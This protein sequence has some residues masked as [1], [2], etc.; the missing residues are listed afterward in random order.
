MAVAVGRRSALASAISLPLLVLDGCA[1]IETDLGGARGVLQDAVTFYGI[2][3]GIAQVAELA[4]PAL[5]PVVAAVVAILGPLI[6]AAKATLA[7]STASVANMAAQAETIRAKAVILVT[8]TA[9]VIKV[10]P[11]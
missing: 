6:D 11:S 9:Q 10:V 2:A 7:S 4:D 8:S 1:A 5:V 3:L